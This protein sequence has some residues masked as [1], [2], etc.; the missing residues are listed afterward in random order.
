MTAA[1]TAGLRVL[2]VDD[3]APALDEMCQLLREAPGVTSVEAAADALTALRMIPTTTPDAVFLDI[4]MP[5]MDGLELAG[6]LGRMTDP[7][8]IVFVTAFEQHAVSAYGVGA[9]DYLLKPVSAE[10][11]GAALG[12]VHRVRNAGAAPAQAVDELAAVPVE[13]G[14]R[15]R[16]VRRAD[17]RFAEAQGDY[18]R[19]HTRNG[20]HLVRI[21]ISR[22]EEHW[23][24]AGFSRVHRSY[25]LAV[26][27][28]QEL[29][30]DVSGGLRAHTDVGDV[31]VSRRHA[32]ELR[33]RLLDAATRGEFDSG[34][35]RDGR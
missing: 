27:A 19:L 12:R 2:V 6:L 32:R 5:G 28:V 9:V 7:P 13:L 24:P 14:G 18:V 26:H 30:S 23:Q 17:V 22:L 31:P 4:S 33:D 35:R 29:R 20:S 25:L 34:A 1:A 10:R 16:F 3:V 11:L 8:A 15:T 21:P